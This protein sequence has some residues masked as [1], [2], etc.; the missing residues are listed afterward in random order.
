MAMHY[1]QGA[2]I[3]GVRASSLYGI[4]GPFANFMFTGMRLRT[5]Q[6]L[7]N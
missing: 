5:N 3:G 4:S 7:Q 2:L 1:G 6:T